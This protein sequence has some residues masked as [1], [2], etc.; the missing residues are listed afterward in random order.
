MNDN[1]KKQLNILKKYVVKSTANYCYNYTSDDIESVFTYSPKIN[2]CMLSL[3]DNKIIVTFDFNNKEFNDVLKE[4]ETR[5]FKFYDNYKTIS[6]LIAFDPTS[7]DFTKYK[8]VDEVLQEVFDAMN[9]ST[10]DDFICMN[11]KKYIETAK[12][13]FKDDKI[14]LKALNI[15]LTI[16]KSLELEHLEYNLDVCI[17]NNEIKK[18][19][20][21]SEGLEN[22]FNILVIK[23]GVRFFI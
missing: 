22:K 18:L 23:K 10:K 11:A 12:K 7:E 1:T 13:T 9:F 6:P 20:I 14:T 8:F 15:A 5:L 16:I 17:S 19:T 21:Y 4:R 3:M 2:G